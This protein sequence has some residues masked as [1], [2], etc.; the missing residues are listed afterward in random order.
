[1]LNWL[2]SKQ[3]C[4]WKLR[5]SDEDQWHGKEMMLGD[6]LSGGGGDQTFPPYFP[7]SEPVT[8][9]LTASYAILLTCLHKRKRRAETLSWRPRMWHK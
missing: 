6:A 7:Y 3:K 1:M 5:N 8:L 9:K 4:G 2:S